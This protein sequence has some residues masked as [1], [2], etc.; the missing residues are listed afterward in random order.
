MPMDRNNNSSSDSSDHHNNSSSDQSA[1]EAW[2][3]LPLLARHLS[4]SVYLPVLLMSVCNSSFILMLPLFVLDLDGHASMAAL[5]FSLWGLGNVIADIPAGYVVSRAGSKF[6]MLLGILLLVLTGL[7]ASQATSG[8]HLGIAALALGTGMS[9][10]F[11]GRLAYISQLA[12]LGHRGKTLAT[13]AGFQRAG[14][15]IGPL[16]SGTIAS[17]FGFEIAFLVLAGLISLPLLVILVF[18]RSDQQSA[19]AAPS[20]P[21]LKILPEVLRRH[22]RVFATAGVAML[23][24]TMLRALRQL[25]V[26]LWGDSIGLDTAQIGYIVS[27][28]ALVDMCMFPVAGFAMDT[29]GRK[30]VATACLSFLTLGLIVIP[31]TADAFALTAA[32]L[33]VGFGNGLGSGINMTLG[34]DFSAASNRGEFLGVW[35]MMSDVGSFAGP[36]CIGMI[37]NLFLLSGA[38]VFAAMIGIAGISMVQFAVP[39]TLVTKRSRQESQEE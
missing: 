35:R 3:S 26:P 22:R 28:A 25:M 5:V 31:F 16:L 20:L 15:F 8:V 10:W 9:V 2:I 24:L 37:A 18:A 12:P 32:A 6:A 23:L 27:I 29:W 1:P 33:L 21:L 36:L 7:G 30:P 17:Q 19:R 14:G 13:M 38:F 4:V 11:L 34:A 39:E